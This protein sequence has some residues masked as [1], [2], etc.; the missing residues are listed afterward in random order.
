MK[1]KKRPIVEFS[2]VFSYLLEY[3]HWGAFKEIK[4]QLLS[5]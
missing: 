3:F 4:L 1:A 2:R 5:F